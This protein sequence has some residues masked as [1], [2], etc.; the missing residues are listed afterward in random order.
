MVFLVKL[1]GALCM[2]VATIVIVIAEATVTRIAKNTANR[3][4][5]LLNWLTWVS[6][7]IISSVVSIWPKPGYAMT[8]SIIQ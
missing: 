5:K 1:L 2:P 6:W 3:L 4:V 7:P 8:H